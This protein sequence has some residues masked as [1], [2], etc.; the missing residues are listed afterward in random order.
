MHNAFQN[1]PLDRVARSVRT[2]QNNDGHDDLL[3]ASIQLFTLQTS[4]SLDI[5]ADV[6]PRYGKEQDY[7]T[8]EISAESRRPAQGT[9]H[10][11]LRN[12]GG[13]DCTLRRPTGYFSQD[14]TETLSSRAIDRDDDRQHSSSSNLV[15]DGDLRGMPRGYDFLDENSLSLDRARTAS[16][17]IGT[18]DRGAVR[19]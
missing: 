6:Q 12:T 1:G 3:V 5:P 10:G 15:Q 2:R 13:S 4:T 14:V 18:S 9:K 11:G 7:G 8:T 19:C 16:E 17:R